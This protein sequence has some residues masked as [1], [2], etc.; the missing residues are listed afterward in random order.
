MTLYCV[1]KAAKELRK[2]WCMLYHWMRM[3]HGHRRHFGENARNEQTNERWSCSDP[4]PASLLDATW[5][6]RLECWMTAQRGLR[7]DRVV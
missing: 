2:E 5:R 4:S 3:H 1:K 6:R 7:A